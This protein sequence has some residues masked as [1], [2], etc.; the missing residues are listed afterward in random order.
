MFFRL[1]IFGMGIFCFDKEWVRGKG[2]E[3]VFCFKRR[4]GNREG[5]KDYVN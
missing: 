4:L 2:V 3:G 5:K 1:G